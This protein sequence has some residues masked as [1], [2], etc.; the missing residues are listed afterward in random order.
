MFYNNIHI[1]VYVLVAILGF[2]EGKLVAWCNERFPEEKKIFSFEFFKSNKEGFKYNYVYMILMAVI[3]IAILYFFGF[4]KENF[5]K[6]L[7]LF[8]FMILAPMLVMSFCIDFKHRILP[9]R[10]NLTMF[11]VG[12]VF[13][14]IAG[15]NDINTAKDY[16][17]GSVVGVGIFGI[18][19]LLGGLIAGKEAMGMGD[20][21]FMGAI[22]LFFGMTKTAEI[23]LLAFAIGAVLSIIILIYRAIKKEEDKYIPFGPFLVLASFVCMFVPV[24][25]IFMAFFGFCKMLS[26]GILG[27]IYKESVS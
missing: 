7:D 14:F 21:K 3:N 22:G 4:D 27:L 15:I 25:S 18:I 10:L 2:A 5:F 26:N 23:S 1:L 9:N 24:G 16:L 13:T 11:E 20:V 6:N 8:K 17:L 19:T 12:L